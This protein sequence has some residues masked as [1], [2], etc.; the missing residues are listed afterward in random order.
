MKVKATKT[1]PAEGFPG[2]GFLQGLG[3]REA[4][5]SFYHRN[6]LSEQK[7]NT[8]H[9]LA[10]LVPPAPARLLQSARDAVILTSTPISP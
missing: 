5:G 3:E 10:Q 6:L 7:D 4:P 2:P 8:S 9:Q 1:V